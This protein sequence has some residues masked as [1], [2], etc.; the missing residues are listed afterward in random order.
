[1]LNELRA[2]ALLDGW[3]GSPKTDR[4]ALANVIVRLSSVL[5]QQPGIKEIEINP[6]RVYADGVLALDALV[7]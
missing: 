5:D 4:N 1:M 6:V 7:V 3:R 2:S